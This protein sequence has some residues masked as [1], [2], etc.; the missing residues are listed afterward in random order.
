VDDDSNHKKE[1]LMIR[2]IKSVV[3]GNITTDGAGVKL[4]RVLD[5]STTKNFDPF[6]MLDAFDSTNPA[7]IPR[8]SLGLQK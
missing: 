3:T 2:K 7:I 4:L 5:N 6:L 1:N 8:N